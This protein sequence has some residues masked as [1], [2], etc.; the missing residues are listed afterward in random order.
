MIPYPLPAAFVGALFAG[1]PTVVSGPLFVGCCAALLSFGVTRD[2]TWWRLLL[3]CSAPFLMAVKTAQWAPLFL[4]MLYLPI[5]VPL[6]VV[7]PTL[8]LPVVA[9][10]LTWLRAGAALLLVAASLVLLPAWPWRWYSQLQGFGGF[11]PLLTPPFMRVFRSAASAYGS[12]PA[13]I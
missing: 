11:V 8:G 7:K 4:A 6:A 9:K 1:F 12:F 13:G 3:F 5:L 2:G 10:R